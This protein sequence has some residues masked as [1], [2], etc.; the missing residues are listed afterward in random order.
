MKKTDELGKIKKR[1]GENF[2]KLCREL[3]PT[4]L[5]EEGKLYEILYSSFS[6][7][8]RTLYQD[9]LDNGLKAEF[10][11]YIYDKAN[12]K[13]TEVKE[14][15]TR[16]PKEILEEAGYDIIECTTEEEIQSFRKY[17]RADEELCTFNGGRLD[18]CYVFWAVKKGAENIKRSDKP[19]RE[20]EYGTSVMSIQFNK[21]GLC[22]VS[23][24]NRYNHTVENPDATLGNNLDRIASRTN[25]KLCKAFERK[26]TNSNCSK[27]RNIC[28]TRVCSSK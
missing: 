2:M 8:S 17:Y 1:Y 7:N 26:G 16:T 20:D 12:I 18:S 22:T 11:R 5:E 4:I 14:E 24:K 13:D 28:N 3:F 25:G 10:K 23:I 19:R 21:E 27:Y 15:E 9:I 6:N